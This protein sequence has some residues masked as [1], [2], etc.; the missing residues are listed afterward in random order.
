VVALRANPRVLARLTGGE[1]AA[2][3]AIAR[4]AS[5]PE[6]LPPPA[7]HRAELAGVLGIEEAGVSFDEAAQLDGSITV[8][9]P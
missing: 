4:T 2:V 3:R 6:E 8:E 9:H 5:T 1:M 7:E